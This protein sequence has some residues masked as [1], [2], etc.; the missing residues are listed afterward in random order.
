MD[1]LA[2]RLCSSASKTDF[3][4]FMSYAKQ[5]LYFAPNKN[6]GLSCLT[7]QSLWDKIPAAVSTWQE[8]S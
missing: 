2:V 4:E 1:F 7:S 6:S 5:W 8:N 3:E